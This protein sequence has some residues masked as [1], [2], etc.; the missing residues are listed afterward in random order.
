VLRLVGPIAPNARLRGGLNLA[1]LSGPLAHAFTAPG[2]VA[3][4][5]AINSPGG[6]AAQSA[7]IFRRIRALAEET[8][9]PVFAFA[10]D[11]A[12]SGGY[13]LA[14]AADEI[15]ANESSILG[16]IGVISAGFG[17]PDLLAR[18]G[19]ERRV[20]AMGARKGM[21]DPFRPERAEDIAQLEAVQRHIYGAFTALVRE[22][23]GARLAADEETLFSGAFWSG[24]EAERL[25]LIDGL[26]DLRQI[27]RARFGPE[28]RLRVFGARRPWWRRRLIRVTRTA[29][30]MT[31]TAEAVSWPEELRETLESAALWARYGL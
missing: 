30:A 25:G 23:R 8:K 19:I 2:V 6:A 17:F 9:R 5:L 15:Y 27:M 31:G 7:L 3:V 20:H 14:C 16:S 28:I 26:G 4:A 24:I 10:E 29:P 21:L 22:R 12:A 18:L 11:V 1:T 13:M